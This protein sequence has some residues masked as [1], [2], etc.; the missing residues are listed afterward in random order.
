M[1]LLDFLGSPEMRQG[2]GLLAAAGPSR[3][4]LSFGQR[5]SGFLQ[6]QD[7]EKRAEEER[8][9]KQQMQAMQMQQLQ[10]QIAQQQ[11]AAQKQAEQDAALKQ[12]RGSI[13]SPQGQATQQALAGGG[14][15]TNAN[16][17]K[18]PSVDPLEQQMFGAM[19]AG[20]IDPVQ[21]L[22]SRAP[23]PADYKVVGNSLVQIGKGGVK[24][25]YRAPD[26]PEKTPEALRTLEMIYGKG[27]PEYMQAARQLGAKLT[28][29]QPGTSVNV[30]TGQ[31]GF[32]NTLKLRGD[33]RSEPIYKA[34]QE[35][36]SAY[37]QIQQALKQASPAGDLAGATKLMKILDPGSVVRESELGMAM[38]ASGLMDRL[39]SY[40]SNVMNGTKLTPAQRKDFQTLADALY[41]ESAKQ[42]NAK[43]SEYQGI[44][45]R[46][47]LSVPD[48]LGSPSNM[49]K[50]NDGW[51][52]T[53]VGG[54]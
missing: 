19:Q 24:E 14:G 7:A 42:Y 23:K 22:Q 47:G 17:A 30:N 26:A 21:F 10:M 4:P 6:Q 31:K 40:A 25:A 38:Q 34:H 28:T 48:V 15:P 54:R 9:A 11:Q 50:G 41:S 33:F 46:N 36:Q 37:S 51:S 45:E 12:F 1:G 18:M 5:M 29:H 53:P 13:P 16:A 44:A 2:I 20:L 8:R 35:T 3:E 27:S 52:I 43:R 39:T 32:D 49:P